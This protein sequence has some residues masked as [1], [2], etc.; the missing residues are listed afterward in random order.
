MRRLQRTHARTCASYLFATSTLSALS[1]CVGHIT[2]A[3]ARS[4]RS[5][6]YVQSAVEYLASDTLFDCRFQPN[7]ARVCDVIRL[8]G[9]R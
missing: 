1:G 2:S 3:V 8:D 5:A 6:T 7:G 4:D 9:E